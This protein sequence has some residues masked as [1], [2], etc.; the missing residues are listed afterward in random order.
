MVIFPAGRDVKGD[1][2]MKSGYVSWVT[3]A[4]IDGR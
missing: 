1:I 4:Y 2:M 3:Y